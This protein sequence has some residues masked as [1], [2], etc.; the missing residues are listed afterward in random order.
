MIVGKIERVIVG[1]TNLKNTTEF[2]I[3]YLPIEI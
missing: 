2:H 1:G 3:S